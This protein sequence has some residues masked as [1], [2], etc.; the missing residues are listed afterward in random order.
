MDVEDEMTTLVGDHAACRAAACW[1]RHH[2]QIPDNE[3]IFE[4]YEQY[5]NCCLQGYDPSD[6]WHVPDLV[7]FDS[8]QD[9]AMFLL[10]WA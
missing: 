4:L 10:R 2:F 1:L 5:F 6:V 3:A 9:L 7:V 8:P